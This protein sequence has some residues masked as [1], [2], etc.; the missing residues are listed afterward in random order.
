MS[1]RQTDASFPKSKRLIRSAEFEQVK[2][3]GAAQ[4]GTFIVLASLATEPAELAR[5]G[6]VTS[7]RIGGAVI[8]NRIRRRVREIIRRHHHT[9]QPGLWMVVITRPAAANATYAQLEL[10]WLRLAKRASILRP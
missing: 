6:I 5:A 7:K 10:E 2:R 4:R 3:E 8:R 1:R 9:I